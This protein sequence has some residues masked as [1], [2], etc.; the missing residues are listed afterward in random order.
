M[1]V[2]F[3]VLFLCGCFLLL[4]QTGE[5]ERRSFRCV[6]HSRSKKKVVKCRGCVCA[7]HC[8]METHF[9]RKPELIAV[10]CMN[11]FWK[12][13]SKR[14]CVRKSRLNKLCASNKKI[15]TKLRQF[16]LGS[17]LNV[18]NE[19][20]SKNFTNKMVLRKKCPYSFDELLTVF[21]PEYARVHTIERVNVTTPQPQQTEAAATTAE[22]TTPYHPKCSEDICLRKPGAKEFAFNCDELLGCQV[23]CVYMR[24]FWF[25]CRN[26]KV[27]V[28]L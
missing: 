8:N 25:Q 24:Y 3:F 2:T 23:Q 10:S 1:R 28:Q 5:G 17:R 22:T 19:T 26:Q 13:R 7:V 21:E 27:P 20:F 6:P 12:F 9:P 14:M 15:F 4:S 16:A 11:P 18:S